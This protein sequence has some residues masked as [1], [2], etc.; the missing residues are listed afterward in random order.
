MTHTQYCHVTLTRKREKLLVCSE[1]EKTLMRKLRK[2]FIHTGN[3]VNGFTIEEINTMYA[4]FRFNNVN[5]VFNINQ[6]V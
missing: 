2:I 1:T 3:M 5:N 6:C 4:R